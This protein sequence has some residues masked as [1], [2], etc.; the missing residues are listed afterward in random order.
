MDKKK[1]Q[2][3]ETTYSKMELKRIK[4]YEKVET[5]KNSV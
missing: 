5:V 3:V 1:V 4:K 2:K